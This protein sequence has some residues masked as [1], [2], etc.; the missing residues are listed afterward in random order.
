MN[1]DEIYKKWKETTPVLDGLEE[2]TARNL[3]YRC[4]ELEQY[5]NGN[6]SIAENENVRAVVFPS[7]RFA[8]NHGLAEYYSPE[9][10]CRKIMDEYDDMA[11]KMKDKVYCKMF[12]EMELAEYFGEYF[13]MIK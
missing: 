9:S 13:S 6:P 2:E 7:L 10:L 11:E 4:E 8:V 12:L 3:S 5:L 1:N